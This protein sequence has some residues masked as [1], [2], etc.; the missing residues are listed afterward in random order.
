MLSTITV[1]TSKLEGTLATVLAKATAALP[2]MGASI[3][4]TAKFKTPLREG[5]LRASGRVENKPLE[6][7]VSFGNH[8]QVV[9]AAYQERGSQT[10]KPWN[11]TT[12]GTGP[13]FLADATDTVVRK[14]L[15]AFL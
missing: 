2:R 3:L 6:T 5:P 14:G 8:G 10:G 13:H 7:D 15:E 1:D 12:P 11:Y 4:T 9:Y